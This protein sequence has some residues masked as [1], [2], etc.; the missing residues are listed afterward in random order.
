MKFAEKYEILEMVTSGRVSTF[1]ARERASQEPVV[2]YTFEC[3]GAGPGDLNTAS[4]IARFSSLAPSPPGII[5]KAGFDEASSSAFITTKMPDSAA[6]KEWVRAYHAFAARPAVSSPPA[7]PAARL[8]SGRA[9]DETAELS[10]DDLRA[11][12]AQSNL[13]QAKPA[14]SRPAQGQQPKAEEVSS[15]TA[16]FSIGGPSAAAPESGSEFTR[17]FR[18]VNAFQPMRSGDATAAPK[19]GNATDAGFGQRLGGARLGAEESSPVPP[20]TPP[21]SESSPGAFTREFL[22]ISGQAEVS[23]NPASTTAPPQKEPGAFTKEF[24]AASSPGTQTP[25]GRVRETPPSAP[26]GSTSAFGDFFG[27]P[28]TKSGTS[29]SSVEGPADGGKGGTGEFTKFFRDPFESPGAPQQS[30]GIPDLASAAPPKQQEG[31]FTRVFGP[32]SLGP[33]A[34]SSPLPP[35]EPSPEP[36]PQGTY[37]QIFTEHKSGKASQLGASTLGTNPDFRPTFQ[38]PEVVPPSPVGPLRGTVSST[39]ISPPTDPFFSPT[40]PVTPVAEPNF[41]RAPPSTTNVF[42]PG[43]EAPP[44]EDVPSGPSEFTVFL[45]RSQLKSMLPP[46]AAASSGN[47]AGTFA[48]PPVPQLNPFAPL[49][50]PK[51]PAIAAPAFPAAPA[52]PRPPAPPVAPKPGSF[53]PLITGLT[54]LLAIGVLLVM[55]FVLK[56]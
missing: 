51:P 44:I 25:T 49:P 35:L 43:G 1:L 11:F 15:G 47:P 36:E 37:T 55:Y 2:V 31:D 42:R 6:L 5:V 10:A 20:V 52:V 29:A 4:I 53:W 18:E 56:H 21:R 17:L 12:L 16:A 34:N 41:N 23:P 8:I 46:E 3:A 26:A 19:P 28:A 39:P 13:A 33:E 48:P 38:Q 27:P 32:G 45:N 40:P 50:L 7:P 9:S 22:G 30:T 54:I 24:L 14:Q